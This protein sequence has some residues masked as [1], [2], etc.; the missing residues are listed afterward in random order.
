[1]AVEVQLEAFA[2]NFFIDVADAALPGGAGIRDDDV[3]PAEIRRHL[4]ERR[5]HRAGVGYIAFNRQRRRTDG[6]GLLVGGRKIHIEQGDFRAGRS[7]CFRGC[8][9]DAAGSAEALCGVGRG[10]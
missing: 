9:A 7:E 3:D 6:F 1:M 5:T 8:R 10:V 2:Q 4:I